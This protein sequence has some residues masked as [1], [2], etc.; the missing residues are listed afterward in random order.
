MFERKLKRLE[1]K[2]SHKRQ[3]LELIEKYRF[4]MSERKKIQYSKLLTSILISIT[5]AF[6]CYFHFY[7]VPNSGL[8]QMTDSAFL[9]MS[10]VLTDWNKF[11]IGYFVVFLAK[12]LF[13][14]K[15]EQSNITSDVSETVNEL[16]E[17]VQNIL[18]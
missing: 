6:N 18:N 14:T 5:L 7:L 8:L 12:S 16:K 11:T 15:W 10:N 13:E 3:K 4:D 2:L 9:T 17:K 1:I